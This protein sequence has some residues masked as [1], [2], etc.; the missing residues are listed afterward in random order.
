[1]KVVVLYWVKFG[2]LK[3][4]LGMLEYF[5][6]NLVWM[7]VITPVIIVIMPSLYTRVKYFLFFK[8]KI[9]HKEINKAF[10][11]Q[12]LSIAQLNR[13]HCMINNPQEIRVYNVEDEFNS[14]CDLDLVNKL[15][16]CRLVSKISLQDGG[17]S[18]IYNLRT[19]MFY[20]KVKLIISKMHDL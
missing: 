9:T 11:K 8:F 18:E 19:G 10:I 2:I 17:I 14:G 3:G 15:I 13:L 1:M 5:I 4:E 12:K 20:K 6:Q 16:A 7:F